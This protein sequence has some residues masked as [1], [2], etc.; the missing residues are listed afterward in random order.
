MPAE[1]SGDAELAIYLLGHPEFRHGHRVLP[2]LA[3]RKTQSLLA[4]LIL[5]RQRPCS[6]DELATLFWGDRDDVHARHS[7]ATALWRIRRL[8][9]GDYILADSDSVQFNPTRSFWFDV[10]EFEKHLT[11]A[12]QEPEE[13]RAA[14]HLREAV[15]LYRNDFLEGFYDDWCMEERYRLESLYLGAL[16]R[17]VFW[18][19]A[20]GDATA[21]LAYTQKYLARDPLMEDMYLAA[22]RALVALGDLTGAQRQWRLCCETRQQEL[23]TAPSPEMLEQAR[24]ILGAHFVIPLPAGPGPAKPSRWGSLERPPFVGR[25]HEM[26]TLR[27]RW[28]Q[29]VQGQGGMVL[30]SGEAGIGKTRL[31]EEFAALVRSHGG[32]VACGRCYEPERMFPY[33]PLTEVLRD[34]LRQEELATTALPLWIRGE[35]ARL[36]PEMASRPIPLGPSS[37]PPQPERQATLIHAVAALIRHFSS[38][39]PLLIVLEDLHWATDST[40]AAIH[41]LARQIGDMRVLCLGTFRPEEIGRHHVLTTVMAQWAREPGQ[42]LALER[43]SEEAISELVRHTLRGESGLAKRLYAHTEGNAFFAIETLRALAET[44][45]PEGPLPVAGN[46]RT[47]IEAQL[48]HLSTPAREW[49]VCAAVVGRAFDFDLLRCVQDVD[50]ERAL[51]TIDELLRRGLLREGSGIAGHD[52]E[53]VH[54]LVQEVAYT[55]IHHRRKRRLHRRIGEAME[56]R[57]GDQ[58]I[59]ASVLAHHFEAG[60]DLE[61]A[62]HY[63]HLAARNAAAVLAWQEAEQHQRRMLQLLEQTD[64]DCRRP[65]CLR[66]RG[67]VLGDRAELHHLQA[68]LN[69]RDADVTALGALAEAG[70][71]DYLRLRTRM[72]QARYRNLDAEYAQAIAAA[73]EGLVLA[74]RLQ[75]VAARGYLLSQIGFAHYF[76]GQPRPALMALESALAAASE[77]RETRRHI[78][79][80][81][82]YV[83][84]HLGEYARALAYQQACYADHQAFGDYNGVAWAGLDIGATYLR[85]GRTAEA[86]QYLTEHVNLARRIGARSA[87]AYGLIQVGF[88]ELCRGR[89]VTAAELFQQALSTQQALRT[90]HGRVAAE[91]GSGL[92]FYH[93]GDVSAARHWLEQAIERARR[94][95]HR[96]RLVEGLVGLGLVEVAAGRPQAAHSHLTEA[97][98]VAHESE[99]RGNLPTALA[100]LARAERRLGNLAAA[101]AYAAEAAQGAGELGAPTYELWGE[102]ELGLARLAQDD[103]AAALAHSERAVDLLSASDESWITAEQVRY[104]RARILRAAGC[105]QEAE[106]QARLAAALVAAKAEHIPNPHQRHIYLES[107]IHDP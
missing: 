71:D 91:L 55:G 104:A 75:D 25:V 89:Y 39:T 19:E 35:I 47:L 96:R 72:L 22:M 90:E 53:F 83:H 33:Q 70:G 52:Y 63:H 73:E 51:E 95:Q 79:H 23:Y 15:D 94:I 88:W 77:D 45:P 9:G 69:E 86:G 106:E 2:P 37:G 76:L 32:V 34:L 49:L 57:S 30:I 41:Y 44:S 10:A 58:P 27:R 56:S 40:L 42:H 12:R 29:T 101:C 93:L 85:M 13:K 65:N 28:D 3:T 82:G 6:R 99:S 8:L 98:A 67:Q 59:V 103:V 11:A 48:G 107:P 43:L 78:T 16:R 54:W 14:E 60:G 97:V 18:Y 100:A 80:I 20:Q 92:A 64:P 87:E 24:S 81:L 61:K 4:Y 50:E 66:L 46:V 26:D 17:L 102:M 36:L 105:M 31:V 62:L 1:P 84:L 5:H 7:L 74:D 21:V 38:R 68:R